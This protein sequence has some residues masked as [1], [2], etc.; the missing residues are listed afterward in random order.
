M[1][2][3]DGIDLPVALGLGFIT[4]APITLLVTA[5]EVIVLRLLLKIRIRKSFWKVLGA[6]LVSTLAGGLVYAC[7]DGILYLLHIRTMIDLL[8]YYF[9]GALVLIVLY[10]LLSVLVEGLIVATRRFAAATGLP[11]RTLWKG[12]ALAN[13]AS[14]L[15]MG[16]IFYFGT[17]P[18]LDGIIVERS[19]AAVTASNEP[20]YFRRDP[21]KFLCRV[22][23]NGRDLKVMVPYAVEGFVVSA[24]QSSFAYS[25]PDGNL[26]YY[27][28]GAPRLLLELKPPQRF[29]LE[30]QVDISPDNHRVAWIVGEQVAVFDVQTGRTVVHSVGV[31]VYPSSCGIAWHLS[32][33]GMLYY[34]V[35]S[36][37]FA[38]NL[39]ENKSVEIDEKQV[40]PLSQ[41][42][43]L[44]SWWFSNNTTM[45]EYHLRTVAALLSEVSVLRGD[46]MVCGVQ[47]RYG[48]LGGRY[49]P[50]RA[51]TLKAPGILIC[52]GDGQIY[53]LDWRAHRLAL[54]ASGDHFVLARP[55]FQ[56]SLFPSNKSV[57]WSEPEGG[58]RAPEVNSG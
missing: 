42:F 48:L 36:K 49:G 53:V 3:A 55:R 35:D 2:L 47:F 6:N 25:D 44:P 16:P 24:D 29:D 37:V 13:V 45:G 15:V 57:M 39:A 5:I 58:P 28:G 7:Q 23:A 54:L 33:P 56:S 21:D 51:A 38:W 1:V 9:Y 20:V 22:A 32:D 17:R 34:R 31:Q 46:E 11:R 10:N 43:H 4:F 14:Y 27:Q 52:E 41:S 30:S 50:G 40:G 8:D 18:H 19:P 26:Y 12:V